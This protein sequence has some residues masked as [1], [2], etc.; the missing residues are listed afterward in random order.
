MASACA[1]ELPGPQRC[2]ADEF[3]TLYLVAGAPEAALPG[4]SLNNL[5]EMLH[6]RLICFILFRMTQDGHVQCRKETCPST[7]GCYMLV[8]D[9]TNKTKCCNVCKGQLFHLSVVAPKVA[10]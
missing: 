7:Q 2:A 4:G 3:T 5:F 1:P 8:N 9:K 10:L 6:G